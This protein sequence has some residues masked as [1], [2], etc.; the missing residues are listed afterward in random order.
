MKNL[1]I[2]GASGY[3]R[4]IYDMIERINEKEAKY[5]V[6][7]F[8]DDN[9]AIWDTKI[10]TVKVLGGIEYVK[11]NFCKKDV[12]AVIAIASADVKRMIVRELDEY[13][14]WETLIDPTAIVSNYCS[15]GKGTLIGAFNQIGPN[16]RV[17][18]F[19]SILYACSVGHDAVLE[20][21]VSAMDYC[22]MTGYD[23]LE[24]GVYLGSS[25]AIL[26]DIRI[27]KNSVIGG[28]AVVVK[29]LLEP[30]TYTGVPAKLMKR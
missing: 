15:I 23:Y 19:C 14:E 12:Y 5:N 16:A 28:G 26:P 25:V 20:D 17:G 3:G 6:L 7:G 24:E 21:Y 11:E 30:G 27:C 4:E 2:I 13:V 22:D 1:I 9:K 29:D 8:I 10:N 18:E